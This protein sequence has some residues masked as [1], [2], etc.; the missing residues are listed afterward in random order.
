[1]LLKLVEWLKDPLLVSKF[2]HFYG[3]QS[4]DYRK[5]RDKRN[6]KS[7]VK[8]NCTIVEKIDAKN[9]LPKES[10]VGEELRPRSVDIAECSF[11]STS[12]TASDNGDSSATESDRLKRSPEYVVRNKFWYYLFSF[13]AGLGYELFYASF[14]PIWFWNIDGAVGRR[15]VLLWVI[16]MYF[17]QALKDVIKWPRPASPPVIV[18]EPEYAMEYGMPSTHAMVGFALPFSMLIFTYHRY[19][20][21][22]CFESRVTVIGVNFSIRCGVVFFLPLSGACSSADIVVGL[23]LSSTLLVVLLPLVDVI[24]QF[25]LKSLYSPLISVPTITL[26]AKFYPKSDRWSPARG[27]TCIIMG[28]GEGILLGSWL[29][30]QLGIIRGPGLPPPF[31]IIWPGFNL[32][33]LGLLRATIGIICIIAV[34]AIGKVLVFSIMCYIH[35]LNPKD[36]ETKIRSSVEVPCKLIAYMAMGISITYLSPAIFRFLNIERIT[37]FTEV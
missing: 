10:K 1:T 6:D 37:M 7:D 4:L 2:Q 5:C 9:I 28:A 15:M 23:L 3:I 27:D 13:G 21:S 35:K 30:Y 14:F 33:G 34:R 36:P 26:M 12:D 17:G 24:D 18:L 11:C 29:N 25:H 19:D 20:V 32:L 8:C 22:F 16:I 31:P